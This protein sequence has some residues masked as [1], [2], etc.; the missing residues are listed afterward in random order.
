MQRVI[1]AALAA[2]AVAAAS[3]TATAAAAGGLSVAPAILEREAQR[4]PVG[5]IR[6][7][8][9]SARAVTVTLRGRPWIQARNGT[10][11]ADPRRGLAPVRLSVTAFSLAPGA[12][13]AVTASL[14]ASLPSAS[15]YGAIEVIGT[16]Q[17]PR[18]RNGIV[19]R[20]RLLGVLRLNPP[21]T[22]R[23]LR[24]RVG[25]ARADGAG[26]VLAVRNA[27]NT[28]EPLMGSASI[29]GAAGTVRT[30]IAGHR[31]LPGALVDVR[32]RRGRLQP[33]RYTASVTLRQ[34]GRRVATVTRQ[35]RVR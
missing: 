4:G 30:T 28:V 24:V 1:V 16:P 5:A 22:E 14:I 35:F 10:V 27:G 19:A 13:R 17:G 18:P 33:G 8:N 26:V 20:Y 6:I 2:A 12:S 7:A 21:R 9:D 34:G 3:N 31:I 25:A 11:R 23:R 32:L 29:S 15:L